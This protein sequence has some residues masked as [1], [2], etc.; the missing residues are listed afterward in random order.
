MGYDL[1]SNIPKPI[2]FKVASPTSKNDEQYNESPD[3]TSQSSKES[4]N[5]RSAWNSSSTTKDEVPSVKCSEETSSQQTPSLKRKKINRRNIVQG[6]QCSILYLLQ[7]LLLLFIILLFFSSFFTKAKRE[8]NYHSSYSRFFSELP[9]HEW[10]QDQDLH[11]ALED[12]FEKYCNNVQV[13]NTERSVEF[14]R[15]LESEMMESNLC[16]RFVIFPSINNYILLRDEPSTYEALIV[17]SEPTVRIEKANNGYNHL[18]TTD[19]KFLSVDYI[20]D[21]GLVSPLKMNAKMTKAIL[22]FIDNW[23]RGS[24]M[25][26]NKTN[27]CDRNNI[28]LRMELN[29]GDYFTI[30]L[31]PCVEVDNGNYVCLTSL[32][33]E[34][35]V[36]ILYFLAIDDNHN[37]F[38]L[39]SLKK[40]KFN[41]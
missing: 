17:V 1:D 7:I 32:I 16:N 26:T 41:F 5:T 23:S 37:L 20:R 15:K 22:R 13:N 4:D 35:K 30:T 18:Q 40:D 31:I 29:D 39:N 27:T 34:N 28:S 9:Y 21:D 24:C 6:L 25:V 36:H 14:L 3:S 12:C 2:G 38:F 8:E 33:I 11:T 10:I 19:K